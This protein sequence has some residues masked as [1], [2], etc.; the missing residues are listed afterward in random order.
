MF[1]C[2]KEKKQYLNQWQG[3]LLLLFAGED[4]YQNSVRRSS[5]EYMT[6]DMMMM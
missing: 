1:Q 6:I 5:G 2:L 3:L 4:R